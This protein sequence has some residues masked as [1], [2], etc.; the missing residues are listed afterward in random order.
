MLDSRVWR[1][2]LGDGCEMPDVRSAFCFVRPWP[3]Q[4]RDHMRKGHLPDGWT[5][6]R[7]VIITRIPDS[8][9]PVLSYI[10]ARIHK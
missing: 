7:F 1:F 3:S 8:F 6:I 4:G 5:E 10:R 9:S 2:S